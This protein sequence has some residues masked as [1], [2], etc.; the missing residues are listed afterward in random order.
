VK[1]LV[2]G[3]MPGTVSEFDILGFRETEYQD[4]GVHGVELYVIA[5]QRLVKAEKLELTSGF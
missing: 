1:S 5:T 3:P 2:V 4:F